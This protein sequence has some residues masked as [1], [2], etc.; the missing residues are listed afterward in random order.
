MTSCR[1]ETETVS[2]IEKAAWTTRLLL[3]PSVSG[4][5]VSLLV[6]QLT[7]DILST[8]WNVLVVQC[9]KLMLRIFEFGI[10]L[11]DCFVY[12]QVHAARGLTSTELSFHSCNVLRD[13]HRGV[14]RANKKWSPGYVKMTTFCNCGS[15]NWETVVVDRQLTCTKYAISSER[16]G[17]RT[18]NLVDGRSLDLRKSPY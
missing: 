15:N 13:C 11:F 18:S 16:E 2:R 8:F 5:A 7:V 3:Q 6:S 10:L 14:P 1:T 4:V 9:V 17:R 12:R